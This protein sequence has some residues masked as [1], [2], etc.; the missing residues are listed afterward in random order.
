MSAEHVLALPIYHEGRNSELITDP[1]AVIGVVTLGSDAPGS[2]IGEC[3]RQG[4]EAN[5]LIQDAQYIAQEEIAVI[6]RLLSIQPKT[7]G[8]A[9]AFNR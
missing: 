8:T 1:G 9:A 4:K 5:Q 6:L 7:E 3:R 2:R